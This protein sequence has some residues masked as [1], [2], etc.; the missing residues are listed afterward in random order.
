[1][2]KSRSIAQALVSGF[3]YISQRIWQPDLTL[4][5]PTEFDM[6]DVALFT[7]APSC[8]DY[9]RL[10]APVLVN[11][12]SQAGYTSRRPGPVRTTGIGMIA[13]DGRPQKGGC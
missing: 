1:M 5:H 10:T 2:G 9:V 4:V 6:G 13:A 11:R 8:D 3:T 7:V 12:G